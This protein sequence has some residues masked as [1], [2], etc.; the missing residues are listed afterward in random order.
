MKKYFVL[1]VCLLTWATVFGQ[2]E[3]TCGDTLTFDR[4][5]FSGNMTVR[6]IPSDTARIGIRLDGVEINRLDWGIKD[7]ALYVKVKPGSTGKGDAQVTLY[8][9]EMTALK[10]S[11]ANVV[12]DSVLTADMLTVEMLAGAVFG[13]RIA[14]TDF[15]LKIGGNSV[16]N[17]SGNTKYCTLI[18]ATKSK[19]DS[20]ELVSID[21]RVEA[22]TGAEVYVSAMERL[23]VNSDTGAA[24]F[25]K[26]EPGILRSSSK[27]MGTIDSIGK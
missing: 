11:G 22:A 17:V 18:A 24:V 7:G 16:A 26:G 2:Q 1:I 21:A 19:A 10:L 4:A 6:M 8:Y 3:I 27:M 9:R 14:T 15:Y 23:Q 5:E 12:A 25:Y 13:A 20:R